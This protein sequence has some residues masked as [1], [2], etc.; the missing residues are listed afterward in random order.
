VSLHVLFM[1]FFISQC[2]DFILELLPRDGAIL[3]LLEDNYI[4]ENT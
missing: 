2:L 4:R 1:A 3:T